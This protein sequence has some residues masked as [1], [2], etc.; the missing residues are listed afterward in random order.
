MS[1]DSQPR[2]TLS[3]EE[4]EKL[5]APQ[6]VNKVQIQE[7]QAL[8]TVPALTVAALV[9]SFIIPPVGMILGLIS[10]KNSKATENKADNILSQVSVGIGLFLTLICVMYFIIFLTNLF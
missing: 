1:D 4:Y 2:I 7:G 5:R 10:Y 6:S 3:Q 9:L 8:S